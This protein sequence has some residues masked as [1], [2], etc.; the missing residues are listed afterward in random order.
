[1]PKTASTVSYKT[2]EIEGMTCASCVARVEKVLK[3]ID[4]I[5]QVSVNLASESARI[6]FGNNATP[7]EEIINQQL[8]RYGYSVKAPTEKKTDSNSNTSNG[9]D[10][11]PYKTDFLRAS[12]FALPILILNMGSMFPSFLD[13]VG[14]SVPQINELLLIPTFLVLALPGKRFF[15]SFIKN[16]IHF[17]ADMNS[18]VA[19][20]TGGAF[21]FSAIVTI[22]P[23][24]IGSMHSAHTYYDTSAVIIALILMGKYL[25]KRAKNKAGNAIKELLALRPEKV[26]VLISDKEVIIDFD[27]LRLG[28]RVILRNGDKVPADGEIV[29]GNVLVDESSL[30]GESDSINK[31]Q[32]DSLFSGAIILNGSAQLKVTALG[33]ESFLGRMIRMVETAQ[34]GKP[35]VQ[36]LTDKISSIFVP[37][38]IVIALFTF[39][40]WYLI[41]GVDALSIALIYSVAVLIIACPCALGLATPA[42]IITA[43]GSAAKQGMF[44]KNAKG[45]EE[46][47]KITAVIFD[48]TGTLTGRKKTVSQF[49]EYSANF[50]SHRK[51]I[52]SVEILSE[53]PVASAF[54]D[55][56]G[57]EKMSDCTVEN[58]LSYPGMGVSGVANGKTIAI[59]N[60]PLLRLLCPNISLP[61]Y[62]ESS[63]EPDNFVIVDD[64]IVAGFSTSELV[65]EGAKEAILQL[66][67]LG[68]ETIMLTGDNSRNAKTIAESLNIGKYKAQCSPADKLEMIKELQKNG[69]VVA[70][71]GDGVNDAPALAQ[72]NLSIAMGSGT[73]VAIETADVTFVGEKKSLTSVTQFVLLAKKT[74]RIINQNLFWAFIYN[75]IGI[76]L[77]AFGLLN[78]IVAAFAMSLS[79]VSVISNSLR[80]KRPIN[81]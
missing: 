55:F 72:A 45:L 14:L 69:A 49:M 62:K 26:T 81:L 6:T 52:L 79:S 20:G 40:A 65:I 24:F 60:E 78:P 2:L 34:S 48:K 33:E 47:S 61:Q 70:M 10:E 7:T 17:S 28:D 75:T 19:I 73:S 25:E 32:T 38:V 31:S 51:E 35:P 71:I 80:L 43:V 29:S 58:F 53:H 74:H 37:V 23:S 77:A 67:A 42:A 9:S 57:I 56:L 16:L 18:L 1:M 64:E 30:T 76:P 22:F 5:D 59:G 63:V 54:V 4:G 12:I 39:T 11:N 44:V 68:I 3:K 36:E 46:A 21:L 13:F 15:I 41:S 8:K 66:N 27:D 50:N